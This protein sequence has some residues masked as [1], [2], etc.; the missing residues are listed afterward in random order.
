MT[1]KRFVATYFSDDEPERK[2]LY[3]DAQHGFCIPAHV[4][5]GAMR[6]SRTTTVRAG[7]STVSPRAILS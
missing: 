2:I 4:N 6:A 1:E 3:E 7:R 5:H